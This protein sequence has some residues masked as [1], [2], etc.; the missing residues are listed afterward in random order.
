MDWV[1]NVA[2]LGLCGLGTLLVWSATRPT[3]G[4]AV[5]KKHLITVAVGLVLGFV[6]SRL[7]FRNLRS[8]APIFYVVS[9]LGLAAALV[10]GIGSMQNGTRG[11]IPVTAG[12][13]LQ[14]AEFAKL[15][16][17]VL[18]AAML[19]EK[20]DLEFAPRNS[21]VVR[22]LL[23]VAIAMGLI[24][25]Q[26]DLGTALV[27]I[28]VILGAVAVSGAPARWL[29]IIVVGVALAAILA[30]QLHFLKSYQVGR[31]TAFTNPNATTQDAGYNA[32][33]ARLAIGSGGLTGKGLFHGAQTNG[34]FVFASSNDFVFAVAGEELGFAGGAVIIGLTGVILLRGLRIATRS[35]DRFGRLVATG[36]V[37]WF[38]F[39][40]FENIGMNLG[41]MPVTGIPLPFVSYGGS[42]MVTNLVAIGLL[43]SIHRENHAS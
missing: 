25:L 19:S 5:M 1:L 40:S 2:V 13:F 14:P 20:R 30:V 18:L 27:F 28:M 24:M 33:Q 6:V 3:S 16:V 39:Q 35:E 11:W 10:P 26:P 4:D 38:A 32:H 17:V 15:A 23:V 43:Q 37:C 42:A 34:G 12:F 7:D 36:I 29:I 8:Y 41:I 22:S 21:D 9:C 31:L